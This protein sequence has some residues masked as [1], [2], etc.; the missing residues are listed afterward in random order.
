MTAYSI[1]VQIDAEYEDKASAEMVRRAVK[2]ALIAAG[3]KGLA[4]LSVVVTDAESVYALNQQYLGHEE[5]TDV[6]S[7][8]NEDD[9][10]PQ[11]PG[12]PPYLGDVLIAYPVA[13]QQAAQAGHSVAAELRLLAAHGTLHLLGYD[14]ETDEDRVAMWAIQDKA[15]AALANGG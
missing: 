1:H 14:H 8:A 15:L 7:F 11:E 13:E 3:E 9:G 12:E 10:M 4:A 5:P 6:L 2:Q